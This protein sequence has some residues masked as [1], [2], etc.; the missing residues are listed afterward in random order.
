M[1]DATGSKTSNAQVIFTPEWL[2]LF[3]RRERSPPNPT[4]ATDDSSRDRKSWKT[5]RCCWK[6]AK[7]HPERMSPSQKPQNRTSGTRKLSHPSKRGRLK[8]LLHDHLFM[9]L[10]C[11]PPAPRPARSRKRKCTEGVDME[12]CDHSSVGSGEQA[13][14]PKLRSWDPRSWSVASWENCAGR[15]KE[16]DCSSGWVRECRAHV[17]LSSLISL[18]VYISQ[19]PSHLERIAAFN[20]RGYVDVT[21]PVCIGSIVTTCALSLRGSSYLGVNYLT[22]RSPADLISGQRR[23]GITVNIWRS[24]SLHA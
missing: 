9:R 14:T 16:R 2:G 10:S 12:G 15:E 7:V 21:L 23:V 3:G 20:S 13:S 6:C 19:F 1:S 24:P 22:N 17:C 5:S 8:R 18:L 11:L 4:G